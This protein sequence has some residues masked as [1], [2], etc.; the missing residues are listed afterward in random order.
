MKRDGWAGGK[1]QQIVQTR[2]AS[3]KDG[4]GRFRKQAWSS[5]TSGRPR[6]TNF[7]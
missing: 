2:E 3:N 4:N 7:D 1:L 6:K 5:S